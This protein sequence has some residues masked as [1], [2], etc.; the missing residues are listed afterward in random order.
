MYKVNNIN[1]LRGKGFSIFTEGYIDL[2]N[3]Y[4]KLPV[5]VVSGIAESRCERE[6]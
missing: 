1:M 2:F 3:D 6:V 4:N 5:F